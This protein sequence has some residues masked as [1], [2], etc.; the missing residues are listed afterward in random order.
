[1]RRIRMVA[2]L[3]I[4][5]EKTAV[6]T[7]SEHAPNDAA[8]ASGRYELLNVFG[9]ATGEASR[10]IEGELLP[11]APLG[12]K[13]RLVSVDE[14]LEV[15]RRRVLEAEKRIARQASLVQQME[16]RG[17]AAIAEVGRSLL[18]AFQESLQAARRHVER[19]KAFP[20]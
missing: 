3:G 5:R 7:S 10:A 8:P 17:E 14:P 18:H 20:H 16:R 12:Y 1:M 19:L 13:W 2:L 15:A 4:P 11:A 6:L 9:T